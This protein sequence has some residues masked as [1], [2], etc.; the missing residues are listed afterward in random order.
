MFEKIDH[1]NLTVTDLKQ[2]L[3]WYAKVF[4][5]EQ[6]ESGQAMGAS[7]AIIGRKDF[8]LCMYEAKDKD[9]VQ[10]RPESNFHQIYHFGVRVTDA[11]AW[12]EVIL[13]NN[14]K[15]HYGGEVKY[16]KSTSWYIQD[17]SGHEIEVSY[18]EKGLWT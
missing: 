10:L 15:L 13:K 2:S 7:Y 14:L 6:M 18:S 3:E 12:R 1:I 4:G 17:P 9:N 11:K 8:A 16:P 5:F